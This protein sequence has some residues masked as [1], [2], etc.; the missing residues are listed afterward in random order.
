MGRA[1]SGG[2]MIKIKKKMEG[3]GLS[4]PSKFCPRGESDSCGVWGEGGGE[5]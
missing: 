4:G 1:S 5:I 3:A 2:S